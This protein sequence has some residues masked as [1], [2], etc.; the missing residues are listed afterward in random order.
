MARKRSLDEGPTV[1]QAI[2]DAGA[3]LYSERGFR[4]TSIRDLAD[5]AGISSSTMY[6]HFANKQQILYAIL[7]DFMRSFAGEIIPILTDASIA[8]QERITDAVRLHLWISERDR[9]KLVVGAPVHYELGDEQRQA[10]SALTGEYRSAFH[11]AIGDG[12][13]C[14]VFDVANPRLATIAILDMLNGVR[15]WHDP[16]GAL[17]FEQIVDHYQR[18]VLRHLGYDERAQRPAGQRA[19]SRMHA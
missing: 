18:T 10:L 8:P 16:A 1:R 4:A 14:G 19:A 5:A 15:E 3:R 12:V 13:R 17:S 2:L 6:H 7:T 9:L 11:G